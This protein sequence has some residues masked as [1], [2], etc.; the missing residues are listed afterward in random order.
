MVGES[1][2]PTV[3]TAVGT[4]GTAPDRDLLDSAGGR[5]AILAFR[6]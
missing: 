1:I 3:G 4:E 2:D 6:V 5:F